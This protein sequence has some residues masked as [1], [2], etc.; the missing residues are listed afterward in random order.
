M[1]HCDE[2][3][4][5]SRLPLRSPWH[6]LYVESACVTSA[7][8]C[9][10]FNVFGKPTSLTIP[11]FSEF[12]ELGSNNPN[13]HS[14]LVEDGLSAAFERAMALYEDGNLLP[15]AQDPT[16]LLRKAFSSPGSVPLTQLDKLTST[17]TDVCVK[18]L[19]RVRRLTRA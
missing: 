15:S 12:S 14:D 16:N 13:V 2:H 6:W 9:K 11:T 3:W 5:L 8:D 7:I 1:S 10:L 18:T 4:S 19:E 17:V